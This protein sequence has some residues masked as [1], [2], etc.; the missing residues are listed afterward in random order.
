M[1]A[2]SAILGLPLSTKTSAATR[3]DFFTSERLLQISLPSMNSSCEISW[4][5]LISSGI[6]EISSIQRQAALE[7][8]C[9]NLSIQNKTDYASLNSTSESKRVEKEKLFQNILMPY[10]HFLGKEHPRDVLTKSKNKGKA[11]PSMPSLSLLC[12]SHLPNDVFLST[13]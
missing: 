9:I 1:T 10:H 6:H 13:Y 5:R 4:K 3:S 2:Y 8:S 7:R 11:K 12:R